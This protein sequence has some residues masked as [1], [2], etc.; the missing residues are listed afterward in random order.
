M[1]LAV[2]DSV[3]ERL[4]TLYPVGRER[5]AASRR[6]QL[7]IVR[8]PARAQLLL[9]HAAIGQVEDRDFPVPDT[10]RASG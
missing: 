3:L 9:G 1:Q 4:Q 5:G 2:E 8:D 10:R 7:Y 6:L